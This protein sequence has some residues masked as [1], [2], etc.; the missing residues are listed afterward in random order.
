MKTIVQGFVALALFVGGN[1]AQALT[2][3]ATGPGD[4]TNKTLSATATFTVSDLQLVITLSN[5]ATYDAD[6]SGDILTGIF[7]RLDGD[8]L[9]T[10]TSAVLG[11]DTAIKGR[12]GVSG[13][14]MNVGGEW[15]YRNDLASVSA[16][17]NT[18]NEGISS[19][20]LKKFGKRY[21]F[22][23]PNLQGPAAP[24]GVQYGVT[25][26]FDGL[27]NDKRSIRNQQLIENTV[28]FTL[29]GLPTNFTLADISNVSFQYGTTLNDAAL[30]GT[31]SGVAQVPEPSTTMLVGAGLLGM[32]VV[33][34]FRSPR[35]Y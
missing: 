17:T 25:T 5:T 14:G 30:A 29:G 33:T 34:R 13:P 26:A 11:P 23:G 1:V 9:L 22:S 15:A 6:D 20:T 18:P 2:Y 8:P 32:I 4:A 28:I 12:L 21:R 35:R 24:G 19:T 7:F 3:T 16:G 10:R 27:G 31:S